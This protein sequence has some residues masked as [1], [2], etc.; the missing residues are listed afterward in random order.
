MMSNLRGCGLALAGWALLT[1]A[2]S[3]QWGNL[4]I[5][6]TF[7]GTAPAP[8]P[9]AVNKDL[10]VCG[11]HPLFDESLVVSPAGGLANVV[12]YCRTKGVQVHPDVAAALATKPVLDNKDCRFE[13]HI[14]CL[15]VSQTIVLKNSDPVGHN[16][17]IAPL[18]DLAINP[19][20]AGG[21]SLE[22]KFNRSQTVPQPVSCNIHPWMRAYVLPRENPYFGVSNADGEVV[23]KNLPVGSLE[24]VAWHGKSGYVEA[25][26]EKGRFTVDITAE[27]KTLEFKV[28]AASLNK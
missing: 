17:N 8:T 18:G 21:G 16:T 10:E 2:A 7:D 24:F 28:P 12:V 6:F 22:H 26:G 9:L 4:T 27:G 1:T 14:V 13:P 19:L 25:A 23:I 11:K 3:A 15:D 5:K 20:L